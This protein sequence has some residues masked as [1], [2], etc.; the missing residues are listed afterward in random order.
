MRL[1]LVFLVI[2][3]GLIHL[4]G[5][6]KAFNLGTV[7]EFT[8]PFS[9]TSGFL[10][11]LAAVAFLISAAGIL[12]QKRWWWITTLAAVSLSQIL[13]FG[14]W[15]DAKFGTALNVLIFATTIVGFA[16]WY[17]YNSYQK[18]VREILSSI[19]P[20]KSSLVTETDLQPL[21]SLVQ[22]YLKYVGVV[23]TPK[24]QNV[25]ILFEG[26]IRGKGKDWFSFQSE[27]HNTFDTPNRLFFIRGKMKGLDMPGYH[28]YKDGTASMK[29]KLFS[30]FTVANNKGKEMDIAETVTVFNDMCIMAPASLIDPRIQWADID[31]QSVKAIFS[32]KGITI[33]AQL[34]FNEIGQLIN[35]ISDDRY[36]VSGKT[37]LRF[38]FSTPISDYTTI[39][40][41][42]VPAYGEA[43]WHY[44]EGEFVYGKFNLKDIVYNIKNF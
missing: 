4:F 36:D 2:I 16:G 7:N 14:Q 27:Q 29:V 38:R 43:R 28:A 37:P 40:G 18:D 42:N 15:K 19:L 1:A 35:F 9:K 6:I 39:N 26:E 34:I 31:N 13:I 32:H 41:F 22:K 10:W 33:S 30:L 8:Q 21:P 44:P 25:K 23:N 20:V 12:L 11:L 3:H 24:L 17:F 5:F